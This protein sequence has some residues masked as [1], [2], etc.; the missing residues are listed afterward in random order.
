MCSSDLERLINQ[1]QQTNLALATLFGSSLGAVFCFTTLHFNIEDV[2]GMAF[3]GGA[4]GF[5]LNHLVVGDWNK[6]QQ[7][8]KRYRHCFLRTIPNKNRS[9]KD[10]IKAG[11]IKKE[12]TD[13]ESNLKLSLSQ[14]IK[15]FFI[16]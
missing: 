8:E 12:D 4:V 3:I 16:Q 7:R 15:D 13:S 14:K 11:L 9:D 6:K 2:L 5:D 10:S 1:D